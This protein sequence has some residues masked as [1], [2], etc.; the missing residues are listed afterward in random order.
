M[1]KKVLVA[2]SGGV[3]SSVAAHLLCEENYAVVGVT[4][5]LGIKEAGSAK[6]LCCG[7][8]AI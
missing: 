7:R 1:K 3:D 6:P 4:M 2:M 5:C 8:Q